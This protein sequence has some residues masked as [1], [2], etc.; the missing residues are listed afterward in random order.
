[1]AELLPIHPSDRIISWHSIALSNEN[2]YQILF[3]RT[4]M[5]YSGVSCLLIFT[6]F[7]L[8][9][10]RLFFQFC[11]IF[12]KYSL[13]L[14]SFSRF[15]SSEEWFQLPLS[16]SGKKTKRESASRQVCAKLL[17]IPFHFESNPLT[18]VNRNTNP[19]NFALTVH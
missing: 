11:K 15:V 6:R 10:C 5:I 12:L 2:S 7:L 13:V 1:M 9:M 16:I 19:I 17:N 3:W 4:A 14:Q 8:L 18:I